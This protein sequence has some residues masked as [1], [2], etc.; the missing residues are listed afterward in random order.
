[1]EIGHGKEFPCSGRYPLVPFVALAG[2]TV[3]VATGIELQMQFFTI[4]TPIEMA[5]QGL[6]ATFAYRMQSAYVPTCTGQ[7]PQMAHL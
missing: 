4:H 3:P 5:A 2:R 1:M 6:G 7:F